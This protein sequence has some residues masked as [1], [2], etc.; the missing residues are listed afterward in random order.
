VT[1]LA[2][3]SATPAVR[4]W[5]SSDSSNYIRTLRGALAGLPSSPA[6]WDG[7][8]PVIVMPPQFAPYN[9]YS[10]V[11][12]LY[13][14]DARFD[15]PDTALLGVRSD[16][17]PAPMSFHSVAGSAPASG[18]RCL[19]A[20]DP[21]I[22]ISVSPTPQPA[23]WLVEVSYTAAHDADLQVSIGDEQAPLHAATGA[24]T[25]IAALLVPAAPASVHVTSA[26]DTTGV[27]IDSVALGMPQ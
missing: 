15:V 18:G 17:S 2:G 24:H 26:P 23:T 6:F 8:V 22:D 7:T 1:A 20:A 9:R 5:W 21:A 3:V 12:W 14:R 27:C 16:G 11:V 4:H 10:T 13:R 19:T 25:W